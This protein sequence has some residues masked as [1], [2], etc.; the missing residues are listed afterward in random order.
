MQP[1][2]LQHPRAAQLTATSLS[3]CS[4]SPSLDHSGGARAG[5]EGKGMWGHRCPQ[6][7]YPTSRMGSGPAPL[8]SPL[9]EADVK[10]PKGPKSSPWL[11]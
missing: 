2:R 7:A 10:N 3:F 4:E 8:L 6:R 1:L 11:F 9:D 5:Y